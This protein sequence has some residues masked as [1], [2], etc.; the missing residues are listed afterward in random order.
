MMRTALCVLAFLAPACVVKLDDRFKPQ[1]DGAVTGAPADCNVVKP[2]PRSAPGGNAELVYVGRF[3]MTDPMAVRFDWGGNYVYAQ[4]EGGTQVSAKLEA[5]DSD[6]LFSA[7]LDGGP[8][9]QIHVFSANAQPPG[10]QV[11]ASYVLFD[12][13]SAGP[14]E[15][16]LHRDTEAQS[17]VTIFRGFDL[18]GGHLLPPKRRVRKIEV[19]GDSISCGYGDEGQNATCPFDVEV[20]RQGDCPSDKVLPDDFDTKYPNCNVVRVPETENQYLAYGSLVGRR[21]DADVTTIA[22]SGKGV[23]RN[24]HEPTLGRAAIDRKVTI[25]DYWRQRTIGS[26][27]QPGQMTAGPNW[28]FAKDPDYQVVVINLG[29]NDFTRDVLINNQGNAE[30]TTG[31]G[32]NVPDGDID[33][34]AFRD[35]Y[36]DF[37]KEVRAKRPNAHIFLAVPPMLTDQYP[38][39]NARTDLKNALLSIAQEMNAAGDQKVY[40]MEL[41][42][43]G[44]RYGL[45]CDY[46]PNLTVHQIM[47][48]QVA[49]AIRSKTCWD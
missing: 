34:T 10:V 47:A 44:T 46:H 18:G 26:P 35:T 33:R 24:Y 45:G 41:V 42:E 36:R 2:P 19:I 6:V 21:F 3:D 9:K 1:T 16:I 20:R 11:P 8:P 25:P 12:G 29:T 38:L 13:L 22:W 32:D 31:N 48:D 5:D 14:H 7:V 23:Q 15:I 39:D 37:V 40:E 4:F 30:S 27:P 28:D 17:G 49:G 43:Q